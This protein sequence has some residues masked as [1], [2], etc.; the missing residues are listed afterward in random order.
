[1]NFQRVRRLRLRTSVRKWVRARQGFAGRPAPGRDQYLPASGTS[2]TMG[3]TTSTFLA[4]AATAETI[5][6]TRTRRTLFDILYSILSGVHLERLR[7]PAPCL[8]LWPGMPDR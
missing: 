3:S 6:K 1:M 7:A 2:T 4:Q 5:A 8:L